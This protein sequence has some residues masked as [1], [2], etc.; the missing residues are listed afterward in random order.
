ML[1][2]QGSPHLRKKMGIGSPVLFHSP[3]PNNIGPARQ[4]PRD[5]GSLFN[6]SD[7]GRGRGGEGG[8][9]AITY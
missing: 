7:S 2:K 1:E 5:W 4:Q 6:F 3:Q 9:T 8:G